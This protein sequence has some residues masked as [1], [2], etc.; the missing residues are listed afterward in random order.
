MGLYLLGFFWFAGVV[1]AVAL[2]RRTLPRHGVTLGLGIVAAGLAAMQGLHLA[3]NTACPPETCTALPPL[4]DRIRLTL[5]A[6][7]LAGA[8][9][10]LWLGGRRAAAR[11]DG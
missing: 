5:T 4:L 8:G 2:A 3:A 9:V 11:P 10:G 7:S 1:F 6:L